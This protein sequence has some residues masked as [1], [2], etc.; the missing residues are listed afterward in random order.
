MYRATTIKQIAEALSVSIS[1]VSR[2]LSDS[3]E[4]S[5]ETKRIIREY[6]DKI[7]YQSNPIAV[8][9]K[10]GKSNAIG[11]LLSDVAS[12]FFSQVINGIESIAYKKGYHVIITQSHDSFEREVTNM[13]HLASRSIDGILVSM[14]SQT[15]N[16]DHITNLHERGMPIVFFDR[17]L[18]EIE[19]FKVTTDNFKAAY[20]A[21]E[22]LIKKGYKSIGHLTNAPQLSI[23]I[24]RLHGYQAALAANNIPFNEG[25]VYYCQEGGRNPEEIETA[26]A[27]YLTD[28]VKADALLISSDRI[29]TSAMRVLNRLGKADELTIIGFSNSDVIDLL[30][31]GISF[32]R[33]RAFEMGEIAA[34]MLI[35]VIESKYPVYEFET[36]LLEGEL[37][38]KGKERVQD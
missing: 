11:V 12:S 17:I 14:S 4:V 37:H 26:V 29:S 20:E 8:S 9:L 10:R 2:A 22:L 28:E 13:G 38:W 15:T 25:L 35:R 19:T 27:H 7:G 18:D 32:I 5:A 6:A 1:T 33:Q 24:E 30:S 16:Y 36:R 34:E 21:T 3:H 31:P 23:T